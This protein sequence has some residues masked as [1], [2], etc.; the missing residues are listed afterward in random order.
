[1]PLWN[2][3]MFPGT[4]LQDL[5]LD[6]ILKKIASLRG[7]NRGQVLTKKSSKDFDFE[8]TEGGG[9]TG[10]GIP[11]GG[12]AGEYLRKTSNADY[13]VEWSEISPPSKVSDLINDAGYIS[14]LTTLTY[15]VSTFNDFLAAYRK[16][17]IVY[18]RAYTGDDPAEVTDTTRL[19]YLAYVNNGTNPSMAFFVYYRSFAP[20]SDE[21]QGDE[22]YIYTLRQTGWTFQKRNAFTQIDVGTGLLK[23][24]ANNKLILSSTG[25]GGGGS[26]VTFIPSVSPEGVISWTNDGGLPNPTPVNIKGP[27]GEMGPTGATGATGPAGP[28]GE[29]GPAGPTG[30]TGPAGSNGTTF[31]PSVSSEGVISWTNDGGL[32]NPS[33]VNIKGPTGAT[34]PAGAAGATGATGPAGPGVPTGGTTGQVLAKNSATNYDTKWVTPSDSDSG[35]ITLPL[36]NNVQAYDAPVTPRYRKLGKIVEITGAFRANQIMDAN[37]VHT[38]AYVPTGYRPSSQVTSVFQASGMNRWCGSIAENGE[39]LLERFGTTTSIQ[40]LQGTWLPF[41]FIYM[42]N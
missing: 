33:P 15:G 5:N 8:W 20:H 11:E 42:V 18:A 32:A 40:V 17:T 24:Y 1:M 29:T 34:G 27:T 4:N 2:R 6:W 14:G 26:G 30:A 16:N 7:G 35:W 22:V 12:L 28:A 21:Q 39:F 13:A 19:A 3:R 41:H 38:V 25:G 37:V 23:T 31:T 10:H 9:G 36:D